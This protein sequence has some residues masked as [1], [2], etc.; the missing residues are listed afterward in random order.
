[1]FKVGKPQ[2]GSGKFP[3]HV[4]IIL[5]YQIREGTQRLEIKNYKGQM[6][7]YKGNGLYSTIIH[8]RQSQAVIK[9]RLGWGGVTGVKHNPCMED[10]VLD[11]TF[12]ISSLAF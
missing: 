8:E 12:P 3:L 10:I 6:K 2:L 9:T 11:T 1:M 7:I 4:S 5:K